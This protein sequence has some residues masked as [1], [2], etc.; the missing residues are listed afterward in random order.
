M[1]LKPSVLR[2]HYARIARLWPTDPL[3]PHLPFQRLLAARRDDPVLSPRSSSPPS[4]SPPSVGSNATAQSTAT[5]EQDALAQH[6][7][8]VNA[9]YA[10]LDDR[11][12]RKV[13]PL[14]LV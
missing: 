7:R 14:H 3:R 10:L 6:T 5:A 9:L 2:T 13:R 1:T 4:P 8:A 11:F 12:A